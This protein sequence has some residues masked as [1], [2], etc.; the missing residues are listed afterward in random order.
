M[1]L[2]EY[3]RNEWTDYIRSFIIKDK[4]E[5]CESKEHLELHH[6][7]ARFEDLL[8]ETLKELALK[9]KDTNDYTEKELNMISNIM[10]G[11]QMKIEH[12]TLCKI[13]HKK[14]HEEEALNGQGSFNDFGGYF[15][16]DLKA[17]KEENL[18]PIM[19]TRFIRLAS[20]MNYKNQVE[21]DVQDILKVNASSLA[22]TLK[23]L[24]NKNFIKI[25]GGKVILNFRYAKKGTC[26]FNERNVFSIKNFNMVYDKIGKRHELLGKIL[27]ANI[28]RTQTFKRKRFAFK[29]AEIKILKNEC[30]LI[31]SK[32][33]KTIFNP[34][35]IL[36]ETQ[37]KDELKEI[38]ENF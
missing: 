31:K 9:E 34:S 37:K 11:R 19:L 8:M 4:C 17:I 25:D 27:Y 23:S 15:F 28:E 26:S 6:A 20:A 30:F 3:L 14:V 2:R 7:S 22:E 36:F 16:I 29:T 10:L 24:R 12:K 5:M 21:A 18:S 38:Y 13:H 35:V 32:G 33:L 1:N